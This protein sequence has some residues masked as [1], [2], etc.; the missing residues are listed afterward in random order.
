MKSILISFIA[1]FL[2]ASVKAGAGSIRQWTSTDGRTIEAQLV[3]ATDDSVTLI[4]N[5]DQKQMTIP[6]TMLS[7]ADR[8]FTHEALKAQEAAEE[9]AAQYQPELFSSME[10]VYEDNFD[11]DGPHDVG[12][13]WVIRQA[14]QWNVKEGVLVG[15]PATEE[16][17][18]K[19]QIEDPTHDGRRPVIFL[20]PVP[21]ALV[22]Q[23]RLRYTGEKGE[24]PKAQL[25]LGHHVNSFIFDYEQTKLTMGRQEKIFIEGELFPPNEWADVT[26]EIKEGVLLIQVNDRKEIIEHDLVTLKTDS[27]VQQI[28][29]KGLDFGTIEIDWVKLYQGIE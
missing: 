6:L 1:L 27:G 25:D 23:M 17:Q 29:F 3:S 9:L 2:M 4:R 10:L 16:Y 21:T 24:W 12:S 13:Q 18:K 11:T 14:T 8:E 15:E 26:I 5:A 20:K 7:E 22:I 28:D 19:M